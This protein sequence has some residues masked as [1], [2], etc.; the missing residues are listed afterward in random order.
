MMSRRGLVASFLLSLLPASVMARKKRRKKQ[1]VPASIPNPTYRVTVYDQLGTWRDEAR[2]ITHD[3]AVALAPYGVSVVY[4][5]AEVEFCTSDVRMC[6]S[7]SPSQA[8]SGWAAGTGVGWWEKKD[9]VWTLFGN[10]TI[11]PIAHE[12]VNDDRVN[13]LKTVCHEMGHVFGLPHT[14]VG[15]NSCMQQSDAG[16]VGQWKDVM[17]PTNIDIQNIVSRLPKE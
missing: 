8:L 4:E 17:S 9:G 11:Y 15:T 10:V 1:Q 14:P 5:A 13:R 7:D 3:Y 6:D 16:R 2:Q 12:G